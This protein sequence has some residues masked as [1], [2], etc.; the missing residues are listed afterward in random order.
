MLTILHVSIAYIIKM[1]IPGLGKV[2]G[3][4]TTC[5]TCRSCCKNQ[6]LGQAL[7][8]DKFIPAQLHPAVAKHGQQQLLDQ[9]H[10]YWITGLLLNKD[11]F[12]ISPNMA[13]HTELVPTCKSFRNI[14]QWG[15]DVLHIDKILSLI[16]NII[17]L[18]CSLSFPWFGQM[19]SH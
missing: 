11:N 13:G 4:M 12:H 18:H 7:S 1:F 3:R 2:H 8:R 16:L 5:T 19:D 9:W 10:P 14:W 15:Y 17:P 6:N